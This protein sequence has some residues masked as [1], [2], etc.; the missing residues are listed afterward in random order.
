LGNSIPGIFGA[1]GTPIKVGFATLQTSMVPYYASLFNMV[2]MIVPVFM[3][4]A[5][6]RNR[7]NKNKEFFEIIPFA[8]WSGFLFVF[9]SFLSGFLGREFPTI[10]GSV[11]GLIAALISV[12]FGLF[13]PKNILSLQHEDNKQERSMSLFKSLLPYILLIVSLILGKILIGN[14]KFP[15]GINF[16]HNFNLFNPGLV[17]IFVSI[18]K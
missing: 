16:S 13:M 3:M 10:L 9:F 8:L 5:I 11:F 15:I 4:W 14:I 12:K 6:T 17:F 18:I 2:G 1:A 7:E